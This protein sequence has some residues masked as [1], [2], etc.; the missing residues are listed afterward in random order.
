M[1]C[2]PLCAIFIHQELFLFLNGF[3]NRPRLIF[4]V[5]LASLWLYHP[6][7]IITFFTR[8]LWTD[9]WS[10]SDYSI[11]LKSF[12][13][14][15]PTGPWL[16]CMLLTF[17]LLFHPTGINSV[18]FMTPLIGQRI[19][20]VVTCVLLTTSFTRNHLSLFLLILLTWPESHWLLL[21]SLWLLHPTGIL[22]FSSMLCSTGSGQ[23][24]DV[25]FLLN[26]P[27]PWNPLFFY[28]E[29][30]ISSIQRTA[31]FSFT[32]FYHSFLIWRLIFYPFHC[33]LDRRLNTAHSCY[34][35]KPV[36]LLLFSLN[37]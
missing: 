6:P 23:Y 4:F 37:H 5:L 20:F 3:F 12:L 22:F 8:A 2:F 28:I 17:F 31:Y 18:L 1:Y 11:N 34:V 33:N 14:M 19:I 21:A 25:G 10:W 16:C 15:V 32:I 27:S 30:A 26:F 35:Q 29:N 7:G 36:C 24:C 9:P 13:F